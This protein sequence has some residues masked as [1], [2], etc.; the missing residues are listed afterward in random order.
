MTKRVVALVAVAI[1]L[2]TTSFFVVVYFVHDTAQRVMVDN[3]IGRT[4]RKLRA[5]IDRLKQ[6]LPIFKVEC[7]EHGTTRPEGVTPVPR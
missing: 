1:L 7:W 2:A 4:Q 6:R 5:A 3:E